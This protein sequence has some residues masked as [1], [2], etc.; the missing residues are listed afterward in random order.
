[1]DEGVLLGRQCMV[2]Q[3]MCVLCLW[4]QCASKCSFHRVCLCI[5]EVISSIKNFRAGSQVFALLMLFLCVILYTTWSGKNLQFLC[6]LPFGILCLHV[7][8]MFVKI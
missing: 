8:R 3:R 2:F 4:P 5:W 1:M 6:D 7:I